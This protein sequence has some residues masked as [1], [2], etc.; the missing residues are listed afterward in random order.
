MT[1]DNIFHNLWCK[2]FA[3]PSYYSFKVRRSYFYTAAKS[4]SI[5]IIKGRSM[6]TIPFSVSSPRKPS[7][8]TS[9]IPSTHSK[10]VKFVGRIID[11]SISDRKSLDELEKQLLNDLNVIDTSHFTGSPKLWFLQHLLVLCIQ[12]PVLIYEVLIFL[13]SKLEQKTSVYIRKWLKLHKSITSLPFFSLQ[14]PLVL[15]L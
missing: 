10:P 15:Y 5:V 2:N 4:R 1:Y 14:P 3:F 11:G 7:D 6:N 9:F 13:L 8:F 12:W